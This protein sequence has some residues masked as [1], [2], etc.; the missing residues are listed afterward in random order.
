MTPLPIPEAA[1][2]D[3]R[4]LEMLRVWAAEKGQHVSI[5][6]GLWNDPFIWGLML[7][8]LARHIALAHEQLGQMS[9]DEFLD[10][11]KQGF[12]AEW[13]HPTDRPRGSVG[14]R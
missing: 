7:V 9:S 3:P 8:D 12:E 5:K 11:L 13:D 2:R 4:A 1:R 14:G 6:T 10:R